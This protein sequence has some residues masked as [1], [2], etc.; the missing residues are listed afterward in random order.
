M[1]KYD[2]LLLT[3]L[4]AF[5]E[6]KGTEASILTLVMVFKF[7]EKELLKLGYTKK[8]IEESKKFWNKKSWNEYLKLW[9]NPFGSGVRIYSGIIGKRK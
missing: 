7:N 3:L 8:Q 9:G 6:R 1:N 4:R 5:D 2:K